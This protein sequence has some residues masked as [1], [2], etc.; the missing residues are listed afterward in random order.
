MGTVHRNG[1]PPKRFQHKLVLSYPDF[2]WNED[3]L[4]QWAKECCA[5]AVQYDAILFQGPDR[6]SKKTIDVTVW[7]EKKRDAML[8]KLT[9]MI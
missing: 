4:I 5:G 8:F 2:E 7:F 3:R 6:F 9:W 1:I